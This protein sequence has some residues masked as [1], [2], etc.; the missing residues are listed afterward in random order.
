MASLFVHEGYHVFNSDNNLFQSRS[1]RWI[2]EWT[3]SFYQREVGKTFGLSTSEINSL[4]FWM[5]QYDAMQQHM[6]SGYTAGA[7]G[8][9]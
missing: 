6:L 4:N 9:H 8:A 7:A 1:T 5:T 3:A 2:D